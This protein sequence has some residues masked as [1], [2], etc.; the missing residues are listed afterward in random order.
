MALQDAK[1]S[2]LAVSP[3]PRTIS[4][5]VGASAS[6]SPRPES[7]GPGTPVAHLPAHDRAAPELG[8]SPFKNLAVASPVAPDQPIGLHH[9]RQ[10]GMELDRDGA[11]VA[12]DG[13]AFQGFAMASGTP[14]KA[15]PLKGAPPFGL[16]ASAAT[17]S[18]A[19]L[20]DAGSRRVWPGGASAFS[21]LAPPV[22]D[23][24]RDPR[25]EPTVGCEGGDGGRGGGGY[26][27]GSGTGQGGQFEIGSGE[28]VTMPGGE[29]EGGR[30][31]GRERGREG[32][33][34]CSACLIGRRSMCCQVDRRPCPCIRLFFACHCDEM[35]M[36]ARGPALCGACLA[37][38]LI[39]ESNVCVCACVRV[40]VC[41]CV[42]VCARARVRVFLCVQGKLFD[43][44][45][46]CLSRFRFRFL[47]LSLSLCKACS[48]TRRPRAHE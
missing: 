36:R 17:L 27:S 13:G 1:G 2:L 10:F 15:A 18:G 5:S 44:S 37:G 6:P 24:K 39:E 33:E 3:H 26:N 38:M 43:V 23:V 28:C 12:A 19:P 47:S 41:A 7:R 30:E 16:P 40:C 45:P 4:A 32:K 48:S 29:R 25:T 31:E 8:H 46:V 22:S 11:A 34:V 20:R 42:C 35:S 14:I 21:G 9:P